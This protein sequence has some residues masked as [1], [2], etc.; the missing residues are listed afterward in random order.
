MHAFL[1]AKGGTSDNLKTIR[2]I[3]TTVFTL[4]LITCSIVPAYASTITRQDTP[5]YKVAFFAFD[6]YHMQDEN[7]KRSGYGYEMMQGLSKYMQCTFSYVGYEGSAADCDKQL[8]NGEIDLYTAAKKTPEREEE[9]AFSTHPSITSTTCMNVKVGNT[10]I[11]A[12][13]YSTFNGM[14]IGLLSRH[15]YND[16]FLAFI[17]ENH[18]DCDIVYYETPTELTN[19]LVN[20]EVDALVDSYI[21]IPEDE[22]VIVNFGET[23]YYIMARKSDQTLIDQL[24]QAIDAMNIETPNWRT[25]LY[26]KYYGSQES[27]T[28]F[29][30][31]EQA[32]L[33]SLKAENKV[34]RTVINPDAKPYA[35]YDG[36]TATGMLVDIFKETAETLGL[37]YEIIQVSSQEEYE[38]AINDGDVDI[39]IDLLGYYEDESGCKYKITSPYLSSTVSV[40]RQRSDTDKIDQLVIP[41]SMNNIAVKEIL[42]STWPDV[43]VTVCETTEECKQAVLTE[44]NTAALL[45]SYTAQQLSHEDIQNRLRVD[46]VPTASVQFQMGVNADLDYHFYG[47]WSKT[48]TKEEETISANIVQEYLDTTTSQNAFAF[49]FDHPAYLIILCIGTVLLL[50]MIILYVQS[51]KS[52]KQQQVISSEL[53]SALEEAQKANESKQDFFS[54]MSHDIRTPLNVV[55]GMTQ[56]AKKYKHDT[57]RLDNALENITSEGNYLLVLI[58]SILDVNQLE[59]GYIELSKDPFSPAI[60]LAECMSILQPLAQKKEQILTMECNCEDCVVLGDGNR[61]KHPPEYGSTARASISFYL[62]RQRYRYVSRLCSAHLRRL[63]KSRRQPRFQSTRNRSRHVYRKRI[64]RPDARNA[65]D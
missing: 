42:S 19:A 13:D 32:L 21:R 45:M 5:D 47:L 20:D 26:N 29:T 50:F 41:K 58:N 3:L 24:D 28:N 51:V 37:K 25:E 23:P 48:L 35:W 30:A 56:V 14:R 16:K 44:H 52:Q 31:E 65:A 55:L 9:F 4:L 15:T 63:C 57:G 53:A 64:Y 39:W 7:G 17:S 43:S 40:L 46:I 6:N 33:D 2:R 34:I 59:H 49:L 54:K 18:I 22:K 8:R 36:D 62:Y 1:F 10:S 12:E 61:L 11:S 60:A 38:K 27:N